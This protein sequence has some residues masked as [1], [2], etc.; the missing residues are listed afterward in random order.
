MRC[1]RNY[2]NISPNNNCLKTQFEL[3]DYNNFQQKFNIIIT[4]RVLFL[5]KLEILY[6]YYLEDK[7][8][9]H[10]TCYN[11]FQYMNE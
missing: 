5:H 9:L 8:T 3:S 4:V 7:P 2:E 6:L 1:I 10:A 11:L